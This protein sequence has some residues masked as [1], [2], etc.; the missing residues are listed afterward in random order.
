MSLQSTIVRAAMNRISHWGACST[1]RDRCGAG[2]VFCCSCLSVTIA[3]DMLLFVVRSV[4]MSDVCLFVLLFLAQVLLGLEFIHS[5]QL[6]H[7]DLK[8]ENI[9]LKNYARGDVKVIDFGS[10]CFVTDHLSS[11]V[12]SRSYRAPEVVLGLPYGQKIDIWSLGCIV[13][14]LW[15]GR[16]LFQNDSVQSMLARIAGI[17]GPF[18]EGNPRPLPPFYVW[19]AYVQCRLLRMVRNK[20]FAG[21]H[22]VWQ[23]RRDGLLLV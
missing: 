20:Y 4:I 14:E 1:L 6:M 23:R 12:Q 19:R 5:L 11:Y 7:C 17:V 9:L 8:P 16:V 3:V 2:A 18:P 10:S 21:R 13:A 15:T 22:C